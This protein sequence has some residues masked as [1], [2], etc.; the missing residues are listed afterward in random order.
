MKNVGR[1][2]AAAACLSVGLF[3]HCASNT[4]DQAQRHT[5]SPLPTVTASAVPLVTTVATA[6]LPPPSTPGV[7]NTAVTTATMGRTICVSGW[8][9]MVRP[10]VSYTNKLK[11]M[12]MAPPDAN[13]DK[14]QAPN[15]RTY[16]VVGL[17][18][19]GTPL[20]YEEDHREPLKVGGDPYDPANLWP[21]LWNGPRGAHAKDVI[22]ERV[23][24]DL[25]IKKV[26]TLAEAQAVFLGN[27]WTASI[28]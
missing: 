21:E 26:L 13:D 24:V 20:D 27:W 22:E 6:G 12:Q 28:P 3:F 2:L 19:P 25:C 11:R 15:G 9:A 23:G 17:N 18:L 1:Y 10:P 4:Y 16:H 5:L 7:T 14:I 8:T